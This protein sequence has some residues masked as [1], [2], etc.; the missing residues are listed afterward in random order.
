M[1]GV[2]GSEIETCF[3]HEN[4]QKVGKD[5]KNAANYALKSETIVHGE[6]PNGNRPDGDE[7]GQIEI[8]L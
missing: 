1:N 2:E 8:Q 6:I 3:A 7:F 5:T 4:L